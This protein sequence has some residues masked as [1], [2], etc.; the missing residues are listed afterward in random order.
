MYEAIGAYRSWVKD[1]GVEK[2]LPG[3]GKYSGE[4]LFFISFANIWCG[5]ERMEYLR[6]IILS[7]EHAPGRY[8][9]NGVVSN[10]VDFAKLFNCPV[11]SKMNTGKRCRVW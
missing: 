7:D 9:V 11:G 1:N 6:K 5:N 3:L 8:R 2:T 10:S 4:Q